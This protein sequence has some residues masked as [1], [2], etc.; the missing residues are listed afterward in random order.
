MYLYT[1]LYSSDCVVY[2]VALF[3]VKVS[4]STLHNTV[5]AVDQ[6]DLESSMFATIYTRI[7]SVS[8]DARQW[9]NEGGG[10]GGSCPRAP[11]GGGRQNPAKDLK[12]YI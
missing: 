9:R 11:P 12:K 1:I 8:K 2:C 4:S 10:Q 7:N 3:S 5:F 6:D